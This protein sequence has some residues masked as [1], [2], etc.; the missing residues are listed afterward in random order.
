MNRMPESRRHV[1]RLNQRL[2]AKPTAVQHRADKL[3]NRSAIALLEFF[4]L[5]RRL[6]AVRSIWTAMSAGQLTPRE[7][8]TARAFHRFICGSLGRCLA[9]CADQGVRGKA[10]CGTGSLVLMAMAAHIVPVLPESVDLKVV[11]ARRNTRQSYPD[12]HTIYERHTRSTEH[13]DPIG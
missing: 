4:Q 10:L 13:P 3:T 2:H 5:L 9:R 8:R 1:P 7:A 12:S 6:A 11:R